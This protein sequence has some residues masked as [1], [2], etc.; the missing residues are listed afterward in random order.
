MQPIKSLIGNESTQLE[1]LRSARS[2]RAPR[3]ALFD[4]IEFRQIVERRL[5]QYE[6]IA[7]FHHEAGDALAMAES[8]GAVGALA[9]ILIDVKK[10]MGAA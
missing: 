5:A 9:A 4:P 10:A 3:P 6:L 7:A 2:R 8:K 1:P